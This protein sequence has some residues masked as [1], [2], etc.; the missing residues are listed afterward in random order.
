MV[1]LRVHDTDGP[2][3]ATSSDGVSFV[4]TSDGSL[5]ATRRSDDVVEMA[6]GSLGRVGGTVIFV[7]NTEGREQAGYWIETCA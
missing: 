4:S 1:Q 5:F 3:V 2:V 6:D 7:T